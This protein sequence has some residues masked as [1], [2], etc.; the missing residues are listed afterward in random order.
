MKRRMNNGS[1]GGSSEY[2]VIPKKRG[3]KSRDF[4]RSITRDESRKQWAI[5]KVTEMERDTKKYGEQ[6]GGKIGVTA[7]VKEGENKKGDQNLENN[8]EGE[9]SSTAK[10]GKNIYIGQW[11]TI[12]ARMVWEAVEKKTHMA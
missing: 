6:W 4:S 9:I 3:S 7:I 2:S 10:K 1:D 8:K 11:D 12:K 5:K